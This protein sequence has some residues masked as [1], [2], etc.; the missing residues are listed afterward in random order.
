MKLPK[1]WL[2]EYVDFNVTNEE[3]TERMMWRGFELAGIEKEMP[4]AENIVVGRVLSVRDHENSD[5]LHICTVDVGTETLTIVTG[6]DNVFDNALVPVAGIGAKI[7]GREMA[8]VNMR[9]VDS[10]G[11]L[12]SGEEL[13]L[14]EADYPGAGSPSTRRLAT[15]T[16][17]SSSSLPPTVPTV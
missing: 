15:T 17:S 9:G 4:N 5:H 8:V 2:C 16:I 3:F 13:G 10:Y 1:K 6:A 14:T 7:G 11:M 12:C